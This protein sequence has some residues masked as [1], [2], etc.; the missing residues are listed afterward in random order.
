MDPDPKLMLGCWVMFLEA[1]LDLEAK[2]ASL[3]SG[4]TFWFK[5]VHPNVM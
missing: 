1:S 4:F 2:L 5:H 3:A